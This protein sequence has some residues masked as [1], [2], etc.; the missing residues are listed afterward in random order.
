MS[1][2]PALWYWYAVARALDPSRA[3]E[4]FS[5]CVHVEYLLRMED[6]MES[7]TPST[8]PRVNTDCRRLDL[9]C[10]TESAVRALLWYKSMAINQKVLDSANVE[11]LNKR[12]GEF[13]LVESLP[14]DIS[15]LLPE[16]FKEIQDWTL[17]NGWEATLAISQ[18]G[19]ES[20]VN[21]RLLGTFV[22]R[23]F[24]NSFQNEGVV[25]DFS[26]S[27]NPGSLV[28]NM[29]K[30]LGRGQRIG[31]H[32]E[33]SMGVPLNVFNSTSISIAYALKLLEK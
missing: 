27:Y 5:T 6:L 8:G 30:V 31:K 12:I 13:R 3:R 25:Q 21:T 19:W 32:M 17:K 1:G 28:A 20:V 9:N 22:S 7:W 4:S 33:E 29:A 15:K 10:D 26:I 11:D 23:L 14:K 18:L 16:E 2:N 24:V